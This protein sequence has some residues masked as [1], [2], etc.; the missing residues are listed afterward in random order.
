MHFNLCPAKQVSCFECDGRKPKSSGGSVRILPKWTDKWP[1]LLA[2][3][4]TSVLMMAG[5]GGTASTSNNVTA[6]PTFSPGGGTYN[7]SQSVTISDATSG[8]VFYCTTD[9]TTPTSSSPQCAQPTIVYKTEFL[10]AIAVA[11]GKTASAI[12][13]AGYTIDF[14]AAATPAFSPAGG[15]YTSA[16]AVTITDAV[17]GANIYY[18]TDGSTPTAS[19]TLYTGPITVSS[20]E[21]ISAIATASGYNNSGVA[22][23]AYVIAPTITSLSPASTTA[24]GAALTLTVNGTNFVSGSTVQWGSTALTTTYVSATQLTA[25]VPASLIATSGSANVTVT[26]SGATSAETTFTISPAVVVPAI[27]SLLPSSATAG[28]AGFTLT[29]NGANFD[30][31]TTVQ[32]GTT[33]LARTYVSSTQLTA[34]VPA[35][36]IATAGSATVTVT[37]SGGTST[38]ATFTIN[39]AP[40]TITSLSPS[41]A[42]AGG[43]AF[44]LTVNGANFISGA[45]VQWGSTALTT[46]FVSATQLTAA[47]PAS[48]IATAGTASVTVKDSAGTSP[49]ATFAINAAAPTI[50]NLSPAAA[51]AG[52]SAFTLTVN[53]TNFISGAT[54]NWGGT[55]LTTTF[56]SATQLT[57][58]VPGN[59]IATSGSASVTVTDA[60]GTSSAATFTINAAVPTLSSIS[61]T[62]GTAG[63]AA[64]TLTVNGTNFVSSATV[65]W[66]GTALTTTFVSATQLTAAVPAS[67]IATSG[68]ASVTVTDAGGTSSAATFT[69]NSA[70]PTITGISPASVTA[71]AAA[72][73][74]TVNGTNFV[75]GATVKWGGTALTTTFVSATQLTAAVPAS[76]VAASGS[77]SVTVTDAGGTSSATTLTVNTATQTITFTA[78]ATPVTYGASPVSLSATAS[79]NLAVSYTASGA[80]TVAGSTLSFTSAGSCTVTASQSGNSSYAAATSVTRTVTVNPA[81]LTITASSASVSYGAPVPAITPIYAGWVNGDTSAALST[82]PTCSTTYTTTSPRGSYPSTCVGASAANYT[83]NYVAGSVSV[84]LASQT[85]TFTAPATPVTYSASP[86]SLS[87]TASSNLAVSFTASGACTVSGSSL[88]FTSAGSCTVTAS[89][90]GNSSYAAATSVT[91]TVT[92]NQAL[93][94][95]TASSASVSYGAAVPAITPIYSGWVNGDTSAALSTAPT[96]T[97]TYTTTSTTGSYPSTCVGA[98]DANYSISYVAGSVTVGMALQTINFTAPATPVT[99]GASPV[100]LSATATSGLTV[101]FTS[102]TPSV[103]SVSGST[104]SFTSAGSCTVTA[105]QSGNSSYAAATSVS[106]TVTVNPAPLTITASSASISYGNPV[107]TI[108]PIYSGWVNGETSAVLTTAPTCSTTYTTTSATG[109]YPSTCSGAVDANY[110]ISYVDGS[111]TVTALAPAISSLSPGIATTGGQGFTL[112]INGTNFDSTAVV[113]WGSTA[114]TTNYVSATQVTAAV[115]AAQIATAGS[116]TVTVTTTS[117]GASSG[118]TFYVGA[119]ITGSVKTGSTA[120]GGATVQ[121]YAAGTTGYG[122]TPSALTVEGTLTT[123]VNGN[124]AM[125]YTCPAAPGD[126]LYLVASGGNAGNGTNSNINLMTALGS[127]NSSSFPSTATVNEVTTIASA[128]ALSGFAKVYSGGGIDIGAPALASDASCNAAGNWKSNGPETCN[129]NGLLSAF[130]TVNNLVNVSGSI[131]AYGVAA[132]AARSITPAYANGTTPKYSTTGGTYSGPAFPAVPYLNSSTVPKDRINALAD[133]LASCV[134]SN[135]GSACSGSN[136]LFGEAATTTTTPGDTLQA[137]LNIAQN[138]GN[139]VST[140]LGLIPTNNPP[141]PT[142]VGSSEATPPVDLALALTFT[143]AGLGINPITSVDASGNGLLSTTI[144]G[145]NYSQIGVSFDTTLAVDASGNVWVAASASTESGTYYTAI[146]PYLAVFDNLG[147]PLTPPTTVSGTTATFGGFSPDQSNNANA[148]QLNQIAF[149]QAGNLWVAEYNYGAEPLLKV[150][151]FPSSLSST[152][153]ISSLGNPVTMA[154]D[155]NIASGQAAGNVWVFDSTA[156]LYE[157][158]SSGSAG[159]DSQFTSL[160]AYLVNSSYYPYATVFDS[161]EN[162]WLTTKNTSNYP[163]VG[164]IVEAASAPFPYSFGSTPVFDAYPSGNGNAN[165]YGGWAPPVA[166]GS[167]NVYLCGDLSGST[168]DIFTGAGPQSSFTP[169]SGLGCGNQMVLDGQGHLFAVTNSRYTNF[170]PYGSYLDEFT[171]SGLQIFPE[172]DAYPGSSSAELPTLAADPN[173]NAAV[174]GIS[175]AMDASGNLWVLNNDT[176]GFNNSSVATP[177]NVLVEYVGIGAPVVTPS[178]VALSNQAL[179]ARP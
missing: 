33:A 153:V 67:L 46:T 31:S 110:S 17:S 12:V 179:G 131:D 121:L 105:S 59:L 30:T 132:G 76:L 48:L 75:S 154:V 143:G 125:V 49:A 171:T 142:A 40:P 129:Y 13:S 86:V 10:Q 112:T 158:S 113:N 119:T 38:G 68:S 151:G 45:T 60:G 148:P 19:S 32:W 178:S 93:L 62:S 146:S 161:A 149:D 100:S 34:D 88:S 137:A 117:G 134:E 98:V 64:F 16:Q 122:S 58:A 70:V 14:K 172:L 174:P 87:A 166:D 79:S 69:I 9:G 54:V 47:V 118:T 124:F 152:S 114:L 72:F 11:P 147:T 128:Y 138:P 173:F 28:G 109:S 26:T 27:T 156:N 141:Y 162:M 99:Y 39:Q 89:Q 4:L 35:S 144:N 15:T 66:G 101:G 85:I 63:G 165:V 24:G 51:T 155:G 43:A 1:V 157:V 115:T 159:P 163:A 126:L 150:S 25:A 42:T 56:V 22:S 50:A 2:M 106:Q 3:I 6:T 5:C 23:A 102:T 84:D 104:L 140:L 164:D 116:Y 52:G 91:R 111:I 78:P 127:C 108:T 37:S 169:G 8:A 44:A 168:V 177:V 77:A 92:V 90:S 130:K 136:N 65:N 160:G 139:N 82:A 95:I 74:L 20:S 57:A 61:P 175:A 135:A 29:I 96:C 71:G 97:T 73:T 83:I 176:N 120:I 41:S 123:D 18:T 80:C 145:E 55:A 7:T 21:T 103:C 107:P 36:L 81:P 167:R 53:G 170:P 133:M 94:T